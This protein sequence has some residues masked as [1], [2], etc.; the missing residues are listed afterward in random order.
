MTLRYI[1]FNAV[2]RL[3]SGWRVCA[4]SISYFF[5][6][7]IFGL[8]AYAV[9]N[10]LKIGFAPNNFISL[11]TTFTI[12]SIVSIFLGWF[13][14]RFFEDLPFRALG[15]SLAKNWFKD[16]TLGLL[17]GTI[18]ILL[19]AL[20]A[21]AGGG[22][23]FELNQ[24]AN[25]ATILS[26]LLTTLII[27]IVGAISEETLFRGYVLQTLFRAK[28]IWFGILLTSLFFASAHNNNPGASPLS[29]L[30]TFIAGI[31]FAAAYYKTRNLWFPFGLHL[32]WNW[33]QG[34]ILG[35]TVSGITEITPA[36]LLRATQTGSVWL[37]GGSY[38]VEGGAACTIVLILATLL[39]WFAPFLKP[40]EEMLILTS[41]ENPVEAKLAETNLAENFRDGK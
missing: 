23:K 10:L 19:A 20:I 36:P 6:T 17:F 38:G 39:I 9:L 8:G 32:T 24:T 41:R 14:D 29:W 30:N 28:Y 15:C 3:R 1:F 12:F 18:A 13:Y 16:L 21:W 26:T 37:N 27:F 40:T 7:I 2:G 33:L 31:W 22:L 25:A 11:T 4:F 5:L 34:S 35:I